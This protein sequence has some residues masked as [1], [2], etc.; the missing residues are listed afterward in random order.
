MADGASEA[1]S[2]FLSVFPPDPLTFTLGPE[3]IPSERIRETAD[4]HTA[5]PTQRRVA[6]QPSSPISAAAVIVARCGDSMRP[7]RRTTITQHS[8]IVSHTLIIVCSNRLDAH[9]LGRHR[10]ALQP[11]Q[12]RAAAIAFASI[13]Q[14]STRCTLLLHFRPLGGTSRASLLHLRLHLSH[15]NLHLDD[16]LV[17]SR[18]SHGGGRRR[19]LRVLWGGRL[20]LVHRHR[21]ARRVIAAASVRR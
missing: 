16:S 9:A 8:A 18:G 14:T 11:L 12:H 17:T 7:H 6:N 20:R 4:R 19:G 2:S 3:R 5:G 15:L 1:S 13:R 10:C 21:A